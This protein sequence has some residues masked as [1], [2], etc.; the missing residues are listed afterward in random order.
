[1][2]GPVEDDAVEREAAASAIVGKLREDDAVEREALAPP[3]S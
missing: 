3:L 2:I 1:V